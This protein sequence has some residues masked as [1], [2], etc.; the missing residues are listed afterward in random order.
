M[1]A[2]KSGKVTATNV[3]GMRKALNM[4]SRLTRGYSVGQKSAAITQIEVEWLMSALRSKE[5][6]VT[7]HLH[8]SGLKLL[9]SRRYR[10]RLASV[11]GII[12]TLTTF[13]LVGYQYSPQNT[14]VP[15]YR[16]SASQGSFLFANTP[17]QAG[18]DGPELVSSKAFCI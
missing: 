17:W 18:G 10:K 1:T 7:G 16:A 2:I 14:A 15:I 6:V 5:P 13:R 11:A 4:I 8:A 12:E 9:T 3:I